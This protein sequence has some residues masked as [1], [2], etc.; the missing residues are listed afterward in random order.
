MPRSS[1]TAATPTESPPSLT[2]VIFVSIKDAQ[3]MLGLSRPQI[4]RL[5][6][7]GLIEARYLGRR[8]LIVADSV[9]AFAAGLPDER[10]EG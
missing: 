5:L 7:Q 3:N 4:Y 1:S 8:R 2:D 6:D 10:A 9:R